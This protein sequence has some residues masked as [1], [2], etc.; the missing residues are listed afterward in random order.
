MRSMPFCALAVCIALADASVTAHAQTVGAGPMIGWVEDE[1]LSIGLEIR[2]A[3]GPLVHASLGGSYRLEAR[4]GT[5]AVHYVAWEPWLVGGGTL[6]AALD[7]DGRA[8]VAIGAWEAGG[9]S[10][11]MSCGTRRRTKRCRRSW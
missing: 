4:G 9:R 8:S 5:R 6:G 2:G 11:S 1:G 3:A 10:G 7:D